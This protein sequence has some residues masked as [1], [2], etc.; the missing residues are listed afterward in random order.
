M[1]PTEHS[2]K[3][4]REFCEKYA[5]EAMMGTLDDRE[6]TLPKGQRPIDVLATLL[7]RELQVLHQR[8]YKSVWSEYNKI[9]QKHVARVDKYGEAGAGTKFQHKAL[10]LM[11]AA[12]LIAKQSP[13]AL[14]PTGEP[15]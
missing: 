8:I 5:D 15:E 13:I 11:R 2:T 10:G 9:L 6:S 14:R 1:A 3:M 12:L 7:D 4:A